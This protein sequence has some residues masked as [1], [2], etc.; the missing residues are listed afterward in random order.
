MHTDP[1]WVVASVTDVVGVALTTSAEDVEATRTGA[2]VVGLTAT[3]V[4]DLTPTEVVGLTLTT[5]VVGLTVAGAED[6]ETDTAA[7]EPQ[8]GALRAGL[9]APG[10][11]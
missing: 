1:A 11:G 7:G 3:E 9:A 8:P 5:E 4:I 6:D 10:P 2:E